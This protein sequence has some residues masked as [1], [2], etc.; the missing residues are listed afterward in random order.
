MIHQ[1]MFVKLF[2]LFLNFTDKSGK[3]EGN[4]FSHYMVFK[5]FI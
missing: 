4:N 1:H 3:K 2:H 5:S